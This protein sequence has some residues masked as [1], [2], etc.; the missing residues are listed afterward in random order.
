MV[1]ERLREVLFS[2]VPPNSVEDR[3]DYFILNECPHFDPYGYDATDLDDDDVDDGDGG[4]VVA[5]ASMDAA[6]KTM[7]ARKYA[8][9][10]CCGEDDAYEIVDDNV[11]IY[12]AAIKEYL[13]DYY[14]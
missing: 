12:P 1:R 14:E 7:I 5:Y 4:C 2:L 8:K 3:E 6:V 10:W 11:Y 9:M 13:E